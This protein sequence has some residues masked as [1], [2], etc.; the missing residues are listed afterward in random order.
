MS[1]IFKSFQHGSKWLGH[2]VLPV[3]GLYAGGG[4]AAAGAGIGAATAPK[5]KANVIPGVPTVDQAAQNTS[6]LDRLKR[7]KGV[8]ANIFGGLNSSGSPTVGKTTLGGT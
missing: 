5:P 3:L 8:L 6:E 1:N 4:Y 7:R 2:N